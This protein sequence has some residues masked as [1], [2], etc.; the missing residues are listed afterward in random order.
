MTFGYLEEVARTLNTQPVAPP[1]VPE[2]SEEEQGILWQVHPHEVVPGMVL[3]PTQLA[4]PLLPSSLVIRER[5]LT[6]ID[7]ALSHRL[8]LLSASAGWGKTT[9]R[10][11]WAAR[12]PFP[13]AWLS[14]DELDN[15]PTRFWV[16]VLAALRTCLPS[17]GETA[18]AM[19]RSP[20]PPPLTAMVFTLLHELDRVTQPIVLLLDNYHL[21]EDQAIHDSLLFFLERLPGSLHLVLASR[22]DPPLALARLRVRGQLLELRDADLRFHEEEAT[23]FFAQ[24][25]ERAL[26]PEDVKHMTPAH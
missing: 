15:E 8:T 26:L 14:L 19:V 1:L 2:R 21:I 23:R 3:L 24:V 16:S 12:S 7:A 5:L 18:L 13:L 11:T 22:V 9:L 25:L 17:V 20:Q 6:Q 10:S 4:H